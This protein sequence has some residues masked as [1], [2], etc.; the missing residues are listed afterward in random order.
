[1]PNVHLIKHEIVPKCGSYEVRVDGLRSRFFYWEDT[2]GRR[3]RP[4]QMTGAQALGG[5]WSKRRRPYSIWGQATPR[6]AEPSLT[7]L[8]L[9]I[10][11]FAVKDVPKFQADDFEAGRNGIHVKIIEP[12]LRLR[13]TG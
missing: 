10:A 13:K 12:L 11:G 1:M 4:E 9:S 2:P 6:H 8:R 7:G 3:M 5:R